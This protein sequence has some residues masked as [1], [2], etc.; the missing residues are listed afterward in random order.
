MVG[1]YSVFPC[2]RDCP[3]SKEDIAGTPREHSTFEFYP[4]SRPL[5]IRPQGD[6]FKLTSIK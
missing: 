1:L 4:F 2:P 6:S 3:V 5:N